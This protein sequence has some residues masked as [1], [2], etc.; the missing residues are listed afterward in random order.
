[1]R[2]YALALL[3]WFVLVCVV[4]CGGSSPPA[5]SATSS[6][7]VGADAI[8]PSGA[9]DI[10]ATVD[11]AGMRT[12]PV[13]AGFLGEAR[14][15]SR[16][17][18]AELMEKLD[19]VDVRASI[20]KEGAPSIVAV[21]WG[22]LPRDPRQLAMFKSVSGPNALGSGV[23]E[24]TEGSGG[25]AH[26][27]VLSEQ[28]WVV[29]GGSMTDRARDHFAKSA[30]PPAVPSGDLLRVHVNAAA[31]K[32]WGEASQAVGDVGAIDVTLGSNASSFR[33]VLAFEDGDAAKT[34]EKKVR[35]LAI[36][37]T[38]AIA[39]RQECKALQKLS[40]DVSSQAKDVAVEVKGLGD[41]LAS[42]DANA[43]AQKAVVA[44]PAPPSSPPSSSSS[45]S[46]SS[47]DRANESTNKK[48]C[49]LVA[50][51]HAS[52]GPVPP[53]DRRYAAQQIELFERLLRDEPAGGPQA[54]NFVRRLAVAYAQWEDA[55]Q[56]ECEA[57]NAAMAT[58]H[59]VAIA[60]RA[61]K[62]FK[63]LCKELSKQPDANA[64]HCR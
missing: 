52:P 30:T 26:V 37:V 20:P 4:A 15:K 28:V 33:A 58:K 61:P 32:K 44:E 57:D 12:N 14:A 64:Y 50:K 63:Q 3:S 53:I 40:I 34:A 47:G 51:R 39:G 23:Q 60:A 59:D 21:M 29:T 25:P 41:A 46:S 55:T 24:W 22:K 54:P 8:A 10:V 19:H 31:L 16:P 43:C 38:L 11:L 6:A 18:F 62:R 48:L 36:L 9:D 49:T 1:M 27:F 2:T 5:A 42:W 7:S 13:L 56:R 45:S 17:G 35:T